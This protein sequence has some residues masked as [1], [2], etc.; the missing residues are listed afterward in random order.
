[1]KYYYIVYNTIHD[2]SV[3]HLASH[4]GPHNGSDSIIGAID[5]SEPSVVFRAF[6]PALL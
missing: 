5:L 1:M 2:A 4:G 6:C 3:R